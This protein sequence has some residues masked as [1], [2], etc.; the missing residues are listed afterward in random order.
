PPR[1][2]AAAEQAD[3]LARLR[4]RTT[5]REWR[6]LCRAPAESLVAVAESEG[7]VL[8]T[9]KSLLS[10]SRAP[11]RQAGC[12]APLEEGRPARTPG[13]RRADCRF[14][15]SPVEWRAAAG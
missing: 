8:G 6:L 15:Y 12:S 4:S 5:D 13:R 10:R 2:Q 11:L 14:G 3:E 9:L 7:M 1:P